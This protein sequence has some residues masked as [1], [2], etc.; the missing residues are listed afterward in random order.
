MEAHLGRRKQK[1]PTPRIKVIN[2]K[3]GMTAIASAHHPEPTI[4]QLLLMKELGTTDIDFLD[5]LLGQLASIGMQGRKPDERGLNFMSMTFA[6]RLA[7][8]ET[9]EQRDRA[10]RFSA[11][12][13]PPPS[14]DW[15]FAP[16]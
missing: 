10:E 15:A 13:A 16:L 11:F 7:H 2:E 1:S 8:V 3:D 14:A 5:G 9:I 12:M 6:S 4:D